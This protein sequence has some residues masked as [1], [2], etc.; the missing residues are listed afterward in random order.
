[1]MKNS[2]TAKWKG[3]LAFSS[4]IGGHEV[5]TDASEKYGGNDSAPSPK[6]LMAV[7]LAGCTGIDVATILKK[8]KVEVEDISIEVECKQTD[9]VPS[10]YTSM[11]VIYTFTGKDLDLKK[12]TRAVELS[13]DKYCGVAFMYKKIM[14]LS[15]EIRT[16]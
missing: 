2:I 16:A 12:L 7:A 11:H 9:E 5:L 4:N 15:W 3:N 10:T 6:P 13:Q 8:M 1:M 14:D